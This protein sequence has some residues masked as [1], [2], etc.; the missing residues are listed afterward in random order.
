MTLESAYGALLRKLV[1]NNM[2]QSAKFVAFLER[3]GRIGA[4]KLDLSPEAFETFD[5]ASEAIKRNTGLALQT[6]YIGSSNG[7]ISPLRWMELLAESLHSL[8]DLEMSRLDDLML[9]LRES[10][11]RTSRAMDTGNLPNLVEIEEVEARRARNKGQI[12]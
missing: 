5:I 4:I 3:D 8:S 1:A 2:P 11:E 7:S 9:P 12:S 6:Y 10:L